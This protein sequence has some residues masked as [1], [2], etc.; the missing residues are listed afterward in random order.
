MRTKMMIV[1]G[2]ALC[3]TMACDY[4]DDTSQGLTSDGG[5]QTDGGTTTDGGQTNTCGDTTKSG[6]ETDVDCGGSCTMKC[7]SNKVCKTNADCI[8]SNCDSGLC[9]VVVTN[10]SIQVS[11]NV[12]SNP[13]VYMVSG[14]GMDQFVT[15]HTVDMSNY[16]ICNHTE[17]VNGKTMKGIKVYAQ[18]P[19]GQWWDCESS[20]KKKENLVFTVNGTTLPSA[21]LESYNNGTACNGVGPG[22]LFL[23]VGALGVTCP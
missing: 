2:L 22:D 23:S 19:N 14:K 18:D 10:Y 15:S 3:G 11:S 6:D 1:I 21:N 12:G 5:T 9:K 13:T 16:Q 8:S 7:G 17:Q 4:V 20:Y